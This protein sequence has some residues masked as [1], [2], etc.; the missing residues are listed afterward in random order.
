MS[1]I[2]DQIDSSVDATQLVNDAAW[3]ALSKSKG[4][5]NAMIDILTVIT[6]VLVSKEKCGDSRNIS[7]LNS[8]F[9]D[10]SRSYFSAYK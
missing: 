4:S 10:L 5:K 8:Y 3:M 2:C 7:P 9:R 6:K 1:K